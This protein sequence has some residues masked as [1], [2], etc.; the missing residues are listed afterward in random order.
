MNEEQHST[1]I[2]ITI[3]PGVIDLMMSRRGMD[4]V[5]AIDSFFRSEVYRLL[6][7][8]DTWVW[9]YSPLTLYYMWSSENDTGEI[10][11]PEEC[12]WTMS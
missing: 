10:A 11:W 12:R 4:R 1:F 9:H 7:D 3:I 2:A 6:S 8:R 5:S